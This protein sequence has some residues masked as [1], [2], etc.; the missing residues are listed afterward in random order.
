MNDFSDFRDAALEQQ[1]LLYDTNLS[2][3]RVGSD[4]A[5][6]VDGKTLPLDDSGLDDLRSIAGVPK[7]F[8][9]RADKRIGE[10][11]ST[12][13]VEAMRNG[14]AQ[15]DDTPVTVAIDRSEQSV[16]G[17]ND[18]VGQMISMEGYFDLAERI[19]ERYNLDIEDTVIG[20]DGTVRAS[21][22]KSDRQ[23]NLDGFGDALDD[24]TFKAGLSI[25]TRLG[26]VQFES[27]LYRMICTNGMIGEFWGDDMEINSL[28][29]DAVFELF[30]QIDQ[31]AD[32]GFLPEAF[33]ESVSRANGTYASLRE[34]EDIHAS[35]GRHYDGDNPEQVERFV[36]L[37][38]VRSE[39]RNDGIEPS[40]L[41]E[42]QKRNAVTPVK[43]WDAINGLTRFASHD[44]TS[45]GFNVSDVEQSRLMVKAGGLLERDRFDMENLVPVPSGFQL[46]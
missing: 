17:L 10:G 15:E 11:T 46:N 30:D 13:L 1:P 23:I 39:Y 21:L 7:R 32:N 3:I 28:E 5:V 44:F 19:I 4:E 37:R 9:R 22:K 35:I 16:V 18:D 34:L 43:L 24:E 14:L 33:G 26:Q 27:Y 29:T 41:T 2:D 45:D 36:P 25:A 38:G 6:E 42:R 31:V 12:Q 8:S 40:D 20:T